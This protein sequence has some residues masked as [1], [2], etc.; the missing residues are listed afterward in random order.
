MTGLPILLLVL[1]LTY[2]FVG[3][4]GAQT[5]VGLLERGLFGT[6]LNPWATA[7][8]ACALPAW[9]ASRVDPLHALRSE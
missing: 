7:A 8:A 6:Y 1:Y 2:L 3:V 9:R 5:L 4:F